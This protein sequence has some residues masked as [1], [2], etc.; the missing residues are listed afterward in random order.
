MTYRSVSGCVRPVEKGMMGGLGT[1]EGTGVEENQATAQRS[2]RCSACNAG[3]EI[4]SEAHSWKCRN[5]DTMNTWDGKAAS[6]PESLTSDVA[7]AIAGVITAILAYVIGMQVSA[8]VV[9]QMPIAVLALVLGVVVYVGA[10]TIK[11][12]SG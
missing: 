12:K 6:K 7:G 5:C 1:K 8:G 9:G 3:S 4:D 2:V 10:R 11:K